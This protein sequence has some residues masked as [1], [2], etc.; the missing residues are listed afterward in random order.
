MPIPYCTDTYWRVARLLTKTW[1]WCGQA[2]LKKASTRASVVSVGAYI[3]RCGAEPRRVGVDS[4]CQLL[5]KVANY[6]A[7]VSVRRTRLDDGR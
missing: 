4:R 3:H 2:K 7:A 6:R 1:A 5:S